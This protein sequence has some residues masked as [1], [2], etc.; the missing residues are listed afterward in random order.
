MGAA[1]DRIH[2]LIEQDRYDQ[3]EKEL[4][5]ILE[6]N[7]MDFQVTYLDT[8]LSIRKAPKTAKAKVE[9]FLGLFPFSDLAFYLKAY[10]A[11]QVDLNQE[12]IKA[13]DEAISIAPNDP[14]HWAMKSLILMNMLDNQQALKAAEQAL[15]LDAEHTQALNNRSIILSRLGRTAEAM[16]NSSHTLHHNPQDSFSHYSTG[17][18]HLQKGQHKKAME[19]FQEA[20]RLNPNNEA[21]KDGMLSAIKAS[22]LFYRLYLQY[23][24]WILRLNQKN[25]YAFILIY[26]IIFRLVRFMAG[27]SADSKLWLTPVIALLGLFALSTW[28]LDSLSDGLMVFHRFGRHLVLPKQRVMGL[29]TLSFTILA[30]LTF[31]GLNLAGY[32]E[33]NYVYALVF[34]GMAIVS[35]SLHYM[36]KPNLIGYLGYSIIALGAI[37]NICGLVLGIPIDAL[38][39]PFFIGLVVYQISSI[40]RSNRIS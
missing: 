20:L 15:S 12:A 22:N 8:Y 4:A 32:S 28:I 39:T 11:F 40:F 38:L 5:P 21:A 37:L 33:V 31:I 26:F 17:L 14:D 36:E 9:H 29:L 13:I 1:L 25:R 10:R 23:E 24:F 18:I 30:L 35:G 2:L 7:P 16:E 27:L 6:Q 19:H 34:V 3:A